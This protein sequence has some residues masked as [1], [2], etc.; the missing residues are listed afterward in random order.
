MFIKSSKILNIYD[1][2]YKAVVLIVQKLPKPKTFQTSKCSIQMFLPQTTKAKPMTMWLYIIFK[3][4]T[5]NV[6]Q[7]IL[8]VIEKYIIKNYV[9]KNIDQ[10]S[11]LLYDK[12]Y[13][14]KYSR[15]K[16]LSSTQMPNC[17]K[18]ILL[19]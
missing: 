15:P 19:A 10:N 2:N 16:V 18:M 4:K 8:A 14:M 11:Y 7:S 9:K 1:E 13:F 6:I 3:G 12:Q 5:Y 17:L